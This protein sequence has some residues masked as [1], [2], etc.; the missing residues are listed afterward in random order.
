MLKKLSK[1]FLLYTIGPQVPR[2]LNFLLLPLY[3]KYLTAFDYGVSGII[4]SY[5]GLLAGVADL[6]LSIRYSI[7]Y[8]KYPKTWQNRWSVLTGI[9]FWWSLVFAVLQLLLL[10]ILL[11][12]EMGLTNKTT[13][14]LLTFLSSLLFSAWNSLCIRLMQFQ[15]KST[16]IT[17]INVLSGVSAIFFNYLFIVKMR[18]GFMGWFYTTFITTLVQGVFSI[19]WLFVHSKVTFNFFLKLKGTFKILTITL[20]LVFHN[21]ASY[22]LDSSDRVVLTRMKVPIAEI[23]LYSFAYIFAN[24][25]EFITSSVGIASGPLIAKNF[26]SKSPQRFEHNKNLIVFFQVIFIA[27]AFTICMVIQDFLH[28][29]IRNQD[30]W[31]CNYLVCALVFAYCYKPLYWYVNTILSYNNKTNELW[32]MTFTSGVINVV[33]NIILIPFMGIYACALSTIVCLLFMP[34][35]GSFFKNYKLYNKA[36]FNFYIW[37]VLILVSCGLAMLL[38]SQPLWTK[39]AAL[40]VVY[41]VTFKF[42]YNFYVSKIRI[43]QQ[44]TNA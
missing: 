39:L 12:A 24:Y 10:W 18:L 2:V 29:F 37:I 43:I 23:G 28:F 16:A 9:L 38:Q 42:G 41:A 44:D 4:Y 35:L 31:K 6:G 11:P 36:H 5:I 15:Q 22:L 21:Y 8:F 19:Y 1:D 7:T 26:Y 40:A 25:F 3:T 27:V 30:L 17:V 33:L 32:L 34:V 14:I 13:V 20:P